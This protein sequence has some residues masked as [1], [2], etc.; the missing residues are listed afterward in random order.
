MKKVASFKKGYQKEFLKSSKE[1]LKVSWEDLAKNLDV[2]LGTLSKSYLYERCNLPEKVFNK[3]LR[4]LNLRKEEALKEYYVKII[5]MENPIGKKGIGKQRNNF[6]P[7]KI[8]YNKND[9]SLNISKLNYSIYDKKKKI[10]FP[11]K[12][13]PELAEEIGMH[14]GDGHLSGKRFEYRL[15]GNPK[16]EK[17][18][19]DDYIKRLFKN[20]YNLEI[21]PRQFEQSYGF[22]IKSKALWEYKTKILGIKP[23]NKEKITIPKK[24]KVNNIKILTSFIRGLFDTDGSLIFKSRYGYKNYYPEIHLTLFSKKLIEE[25]GEIIKMLGFK[26]GIYYSKRYGTIQLYGIGAFK[27]YENL[28]GWSSYK[29]LNRVKNWKKHYPELDK[30]WRL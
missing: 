4:L 12:I 29:N 14:L 7:I 10:K 1:R 6:N 23:G 15:K 11:D 19:Y 17:E 16:D 28:I 3:I 18:Y 22:E 20:I 9:L 8:S 26:P 13:T 5:E 27:R 24:L 21:K 30:A 2:N 25:V